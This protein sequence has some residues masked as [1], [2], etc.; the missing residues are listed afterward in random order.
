MKPTDVLAT[1]GWE[2]AALTVM[3]R[4]QKDATNITQ[5]ALSNIYCRVYDSS[6]TLQASPSVTISSAVFDTLQTD[7]RWTAD[8]TGYNFRFTVPASAFATAGKYRIEFIFDPAS[9]D[10]FA[11]VVK[12]YVKA[13][14][15]S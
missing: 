8:S 7:S 6:D 14:N 1:E 13:L 4:V 5:A 3:A 11:L 9:G 12:H 15:Y 2:D 10:D